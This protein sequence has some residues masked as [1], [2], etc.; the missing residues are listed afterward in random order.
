MAGLG[1]LVEGFRGGLETGAKHRLNK[2]YERILMDK[3]DASDLEW[4]EKEKAALQ[5]FMMEGGKREDFDYTGRSKQRDPALMQFGGWLKNRFSNMFGGQGQE[6]AAMLTQDSPTVEPSPAPSYAPSYAARGIPTYADGGSV[7]YDEEILGGAAAAYGLTKTAPLAR[8]AAAVGRGAGRAVKGLAGTGVG[9]GLAGAAA[10]GGIQGAAESYGV[11]TDEYRNVLNMP[12]ERGGDL[13]EAIA[14]AQN[15]PAGAGDP[16][17]WR[18]MMGFLG[19]VGSGGEAGGDVVA[20]TAGT[21]GRVGDKVSLGLTDSTGTGGSTGIPVDDAPLTDTAVQASVETPEKSPDEVAGAAIK[22]AEDDLEENFKYEWLPQDVMPEDLPSMNT[23]DWIEYRSVMTQSLIA[24]G[25]NP[26]EARQQV[27]DNT[28]DTQ[29]RGLQRELDKA[30]QYMQVGDARS[31]SFAIRQ[32]FQYFPNG[33]DVKFGTQTGKDGRPVIVAMGMNEQTG[34]PAGNPM[35]ITTE[36]LAAMREN[37]SNP[38]AFRAWTK[39]GRD[40]QLGL[41]EQE[42]KEHATRATSSYQR[43]AAISQR[44]TAEAAQHR[45]LTAGAGG[46]PKQT[47]MRAGMKS[48]KESLMMNPI[49]EDLLPVNQQ[50]YLA[51]ELRAAIPD[52]YALPDEAIVEAIRNYAETGDESK[53]RSILEQ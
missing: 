24:R 44:M 41:R 36:S 48:I 2:Q 5:G 18:N 1:S 49:D 25:M 16:W 30:L 43:E 6:E 50:E 32:G 40:Q 23:Q 52:V 22:Q 35:V 47:D 4:A 21:L 33:V 9:R 45:A 28:V 20:R 10:I 39:D 11:D 8:G 29:M 26:K 53:I 27:D 3:A 17:S 31:A 19:E 38:S 37:F 7:D 42:R 15:M 51:S 14:G 46:G 13:D 12:R 34:E